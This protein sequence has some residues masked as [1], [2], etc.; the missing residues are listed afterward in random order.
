MTLKEIEALA[1]HIHRGQHDD[2]GRTM[3]EH[4]RRVAHAPSV[5]GAGYLRQAAAW[6]HD[7]IALGGRTSAELLAYGVD[8]DVVALVEILTPQATLRDHV[9]TVC[10][11]GIDAVAVDLANIGD[12]I[13]HCPELM[14]TQAAG[15]LV[16]EALL[17]WV[18][19]RDLCVRC[20]QSFFDCQCTGS[21]LADF[22]I[23]WYGPL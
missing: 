15:M 16:R 20:I 7:A 10:A 12:L 22:L 11:G 14:A 19:A 23:S 21:E 4:L 13:T 3:A 9:Q 18:D 17:K 1:L 5:E 2:Y 8:T 6:L